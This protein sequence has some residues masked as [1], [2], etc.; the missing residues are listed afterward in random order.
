M[1]TQQDRIAEGTANMICEILDSIKNKSI[2][3]LEDKLQC[4]NSL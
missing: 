2:D 3:G 1:K 4:L